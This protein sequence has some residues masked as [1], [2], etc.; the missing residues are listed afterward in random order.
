MV[1]GLNCSHGSTT[2]MS[3]HRLN[4]SI[5]KSKEDLIERNLTWV[6]PQLSGLTLPSSTKVTSVD[7]ILKKSGFQLVQAVYSRINP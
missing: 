3:A 7:P 1:D 2:C 6:L 4:D 5:P